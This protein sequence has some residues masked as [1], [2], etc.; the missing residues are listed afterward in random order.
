MSSSGEGDQLAPLIGLQVAENNLDVKAGEPVILQLNTF[1]SK[2]LSGIPPL[3]VLFKK[4]PNKED[5]KCA[6]CCLWSIIE[7]LQKFTSKRKQ[8]TVCTMFEC[9]N[10]CGNPSVPSV[11][12]QKIC[13]MKAPIHACTHADSMEI[14]I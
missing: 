6:L 10:T 9:E 3:V 11:S 7:K 2:F 5:F 4:A 1:A 12:A 13:S 8:Q 14:D